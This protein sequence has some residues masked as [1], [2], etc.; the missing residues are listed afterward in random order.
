MQKVISKD[1]TSI[2]F[3][4]SGQGPAVIFVGGAFQHRAID[5]RTAQ[6]AAL[7]AP[8][9]TVFHYDR[10][11]R[12]DSTDTP[13]YAVEREVEDL[14]ALIRDAGGSVFLF[15]MS[16]GGALAL[17][18]AHRGLAIKKLALYEPPFNLDQ[19]ARA[20]SV[21]YAKQL[22]AILVEGRR[23]DAV[24]LAMTTFGAPAEAVAGM[25]QTPVWPAFE[26]VAPTLAYDSTIMGDGSIPTKQMASIAVPIL[27]MDGGASPAFMHSAA[28]AVA[29]ALP[30]A[31]HRTLEGQTHD[32]APEVLAPV[33]IEFF[34]ESNDAWPKKSSRRKVAA[35]E[36]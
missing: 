6:L 29:D 22:T 20:A 24:A 19:G 5:P 13:P 2:A 28:Q 23:A 9:F 10:R 3:D 8:H 25:R 34:N 27:V 14:E 33:L 15:G 36:K 4:H 7:L 18:A 35:K 12:G 32:V 1:G 11:G 16:S 31:Q 21:N 17:E 26:S 30:N